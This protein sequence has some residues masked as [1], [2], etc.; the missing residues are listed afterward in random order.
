MWIEPSKNSKYRDPYWLLINPIKRI[1]HYFF[2]SATAEFLF[3][4]G[5][6]D[7]NTVKIARYSKIFDPVLGA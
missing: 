2:L 7:K 5:F 4:Q 3:S 1:N 6:S